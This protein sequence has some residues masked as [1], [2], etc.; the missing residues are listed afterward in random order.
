MNQENKHTA[1]LSR[2]SREDELIGESE[3]I[4]TQKAMLEQYAFQHGFFN[5]IH[6]V[7][8]GYSGTS[9]DRPNFQRMEKDISKKIKSALKVKALNGE[10]TA[11]YTPYGYKKDNENKQFSNR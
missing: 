1:L 3:S 2:L 7:D 9:F 5:C 11:S 8:D 6:Y 10:F 4:Q